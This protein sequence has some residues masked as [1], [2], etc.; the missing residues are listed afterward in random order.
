MYDI[1]ISTEA[2]VGEYNQ[3][4]VAMVDDLEKGFGNVEQD[5]MR[6]KFKV[7]NSPSVI[8]KLALSMYT[9]AGHIK[10]GKA[11]SRQCTLKSEC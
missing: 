9:G 2:N 11:F 4:V 10:C 1:A 8:V 5:T 6:L 3:I 7:Y